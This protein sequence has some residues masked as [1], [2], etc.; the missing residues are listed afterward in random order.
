MI[1]SFRREVDE[2][3]ALQGHYAAGHYSL[4]NSL[5]ERSSHF[6]TPVISNS[7]GKSFLQIQ[8]VTECSD[9]V[10][11]LNLC[12]F[13]SYSYRRSSLN[14]SGVELRSISAE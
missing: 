6:H 4:R 5:E 10:I 9:M 12:N 14:V 3:C 13:L 8:D 11:Y 1:A 7:K 2:Y